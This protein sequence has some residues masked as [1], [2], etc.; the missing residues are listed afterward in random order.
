MVHPLRAKETMIFIQRKLS[1]RQ[2]QVAELYCK[3]FSN[4]DI[5]QA[6]GISRG[7]VG[8][9][10]TIVKAKLQLWTIEELRLRPQC[11]LTK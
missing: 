9:I 8:M 2:H 5:A 1:P 7:R 4:T 10:L 6:L 3:G 11:L